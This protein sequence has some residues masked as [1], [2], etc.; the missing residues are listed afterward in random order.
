LWGINFYNTKRLSPDL[1]AVL[2]AN[3]ET[4]KKG[5]TKGYMAL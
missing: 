1:M 5:N 3:R 2:M 4:I